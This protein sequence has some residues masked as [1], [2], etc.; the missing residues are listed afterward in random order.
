MIDI[1]PTVQPIPDSIRTLVRG[2]RSVR[3]EEG[4]VI[5]ESALSIIILLTFLFGVIEAGFAL[6]SY[7]FISEAAR[8]GTRYAIVR[9]S[10]AGTAKCTAPGPPTC[11]AQAADIQTYVK[12]LGFPGINP[13]NMTVAS[14][15]SIY[16]NAKS[17]PAAGP[18]NSAGNLVTITVTYNFPFRVP[19]VPAQTWAMTSR[20]AMI[21]QN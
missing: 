21:I 20:A 9:G 1:R 11:I 15:W 7:H 5:V 19:F 8:E 14:A 13:G 6:Y 4:S 2:Q 12:N 17:C 18:C 16:P 3:G 10:L